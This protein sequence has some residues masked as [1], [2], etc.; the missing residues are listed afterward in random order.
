MR[1]LVAP[2]FLDHDP[3]PGQP[4]G[5]EG[6]EYVVATMHGAHPDLRFAIDDLVAEER[7]VVTPLDDARNQ[8]RPAASASRPPVSRSSSR[9]S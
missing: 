3:L 6:A 2:D 5:G 4:A 1:D 9:R 7:S 8:H